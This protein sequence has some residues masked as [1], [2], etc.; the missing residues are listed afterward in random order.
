MTDSKNKIHHI[1]V[2]GMPEGVHQEIYKLLGVKDPLK[3][4]HQIVG[5]RL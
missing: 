2:S 4:N 1:R 3:K 5:T